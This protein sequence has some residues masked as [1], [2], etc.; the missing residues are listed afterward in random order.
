MKLVKAIERYYGEI[1]SGLYL[2]GISTG[3][4][5]NS[6]MNMINLYSYD[7]DFQRDI[8]I[9]DKFEVIV[10]V[11]YDP[12][13]IR[14]RDGNILLSSITTRGKTITMYLHEYKNSFEYFNKEGNSIKKSLLC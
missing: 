6:V 10:E 7:I 12:E 11:F 4:S 1:K 3:L 9:G 14:I 2:D 8:R 13:G 5:S